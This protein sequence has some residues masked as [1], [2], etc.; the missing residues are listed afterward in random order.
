MSLIKCNEC[1]NQISTFANSC[2]KC[3]APVGVVSGLSPNAERKGNSFSLIAFSVLIVLV[4]VGLLLPKYLEMKEDEKKIEAE[5]ERIKNLP[6]LPISV[7]YRSAL[8][9]SG[10]VGQFKNNSSR[11][12][13]VIMSA[14]N[15]SLNQSKNFRLDIAPN[16]TKEIG[17]MEGWVFASGDIVTIS[18][19][20]YKTAEFKIP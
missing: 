6:Q 12:L 4:F 15:P 11:Y 17:H 9:G 7:G 18:H 13:T 1:E 8:M 10:L 20:E 16:E 2:P 14:Y 3:G 19:D 5:I